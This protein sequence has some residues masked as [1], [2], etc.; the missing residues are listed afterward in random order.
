MTFLYLNSDQMG[1]GDEEL[2]EILLNSFLQNLAE[3][4]VQIDAVGCVNAGVN[5]T[6]NVGPALDSLKKL[7]AKGAQIMSC[8]TCL[9][10]H[11]IREKL[12][13]GGIGSMVQNVQAMA[14]AEKVIRV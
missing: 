14:T 8:C 13:I 11:G 3:S 5:L 1:K 2:G 9:D 10:Y 7:E 4:D 12:L 6:T